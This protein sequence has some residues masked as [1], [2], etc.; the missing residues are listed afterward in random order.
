MAPERIVRRLLKECLGYPVSRERF[1]ELFEMIPESLNPCVRKDGE[2]IT[3][4]ILENNLY[5]MIEKVQGEDTFYIP[6]P[7]EILDYT[8]TDIPPQIP[9]M[10]G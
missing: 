9:F 3:R 10:A 6:S 8:E 1:A 7:E 5:E 2:L 4:E